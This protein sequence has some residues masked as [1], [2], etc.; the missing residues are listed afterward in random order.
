MLEIFVNSSHNCPSVFIAVSDDDNCCWKYS[1]LF[2]RHLARNSSWSHEFGV[3]IKQAAE[4]AYRALYCFPH[5]FSN[6]YSFFRTIVTIWIASI[7]GRF[8]DIWLPTSFYTYIQCACRGVHQNVFS[9]LKYR[10]TLNWWGFPSSFT[11]LFLCHLRRFPCV[12]KWR[13]QNE[14]LT[15]CTG[16]RAALQHFAFEYSTVDPG[17][18]PTH[19][20]SRLSSCQR[21]RED[22]VQRALEHLIPEPYPWLAKPF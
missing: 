12:W 5:S 20:K 13:R 3:S 1:S 6:A 10:R 19:P 17:A 21:E 15:P 11:T 8:P 2:P 14:N 16:S 4:T 7:L 18:P 22:R 9:K